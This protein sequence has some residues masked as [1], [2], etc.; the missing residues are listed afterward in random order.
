MACCCCGPHRQPNCTLGNIVQVHTCKAVLLLKLWLGPALLP[1]P[2]LQPKLLLLCRRPPAL[3]PQST[4]RCPRALDW[5]WHASLALLPLLLLLLP[6]STFSRLLIGLL[7]Q[8]RNIPNTQLQLKTLAAL[9][10]T[11]VTADMCA[12]SHHWCTFTIPRCTVSVPFT[13]AALS[14]FWPITN[15]HRCTWYFTRL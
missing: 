10:V 13:P 3:C 7:Q 2:L 14:A 5:T 4:S 12:Q 1:Q 15:Q 6:L 11:I 9:A 8:K